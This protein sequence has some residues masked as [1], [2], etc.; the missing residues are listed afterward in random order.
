MATDMRKGHPG[1]EVFGEMYLPGYPYAADRLGPENRMMSR[2]QAL[3]KRNIQTNR[4]GLVNLLT[5]DIDRPD[6]VVRALE[7]RDGWRPTWV[8]ENLRNGHVHSGWRL[9]GPVAVTDAARPKPRYLAAD[10]QEGLRIS[11][12]G[13]TSYSG[14]MT[15]N[16]LHPDWK[17]YWGP[18]E[19]LA[20]Y[21]LRELADHL[22]TAG[23]M[24]PYGWMGRRG[25]DLTGLGRNCSIF[26]HLREW[27]YPQIN[28]Y[29]GDLGGLGEAI[30]RTALQINVDL[31]PNDPLPY[32]EVR[33]IARS[34]TRFIG[35]SR[36]WQAGPA[37]SD[38]RF[39]ARQSYRG[40][41]SGEVRRKKSRERGDRA[42]ENLAAILESEGYEQGREGAASA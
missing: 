33:Q 26:E 2:E 36:M 5:V 12:G 16:P 28:N 1:E 21:E 30:E 39:K 11:T 18:E 20:G 24:P 31:F 41:V 42:M 7:A 23:F 9:S 19:A 34:I 4:H 3:T 37:M 32:A 8:A 29:W 27:A 15:K 14:F 25:K 10:V 35:R 40:R 22:R 17:V 13:D 6:G 38:E